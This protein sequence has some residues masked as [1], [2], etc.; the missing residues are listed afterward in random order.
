ML[1]AECTTR[2][3]MNLSC[4]TNSTKIR[5]RSWRVEQNASRLHSHQLPIRVP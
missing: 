3:I 1:N 5:T 2:S 4:T